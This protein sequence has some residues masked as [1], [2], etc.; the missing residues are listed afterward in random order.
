MPTCNLSCLDQ[1]W[2]NELGQQPFFG[3]VRI[4]PEGG[5]Y[6]QANQALNWVVLACNYS[7]ALSIIFN[8]SL[9]IKQIAATYFMNVCLRCSKLI[10]FIC[11]CVSINVQLNWLYSNKCINLEHLT[12]TEELLVKHISY[13]YLIVM[14]G[15]LKTLKKYY[16]RHFDCAQLFF[17]HDYGTITFNS[18]DRLTD[19]LRHF[20]C[21]GTVFTVVVHSISFFFFVHLMRRVTK[22]YLITK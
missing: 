6:K 4:V 20:F 21:P 19:L 12:Q 22:K 2:A 1:H 13:Q 16:L 11:C 3:P 9:W 7:L 14:N 15:K 10:F 5:N 18:T 8:V 17:N